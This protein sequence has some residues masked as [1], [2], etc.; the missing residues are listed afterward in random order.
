[1]R[2][3]YSMF[4]FSGSKEVGFVSGGIEYVNKAVSYN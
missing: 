2:S 3:G 1:M 4:R